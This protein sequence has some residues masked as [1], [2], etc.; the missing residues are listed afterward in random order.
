M[1]INRIKKGEITISKQEKNNKIPKQKIERLYIIIR[2]E[3]LRT[4][5]AK[6]NAVNIKTDKKNKKS[7]PQ[8]FEIL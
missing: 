4:T 5:K 7:A 2:K 3:T 6:Q 8:I 1:I